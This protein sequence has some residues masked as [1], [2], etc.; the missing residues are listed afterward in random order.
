[1]GLFPLKAPAFSSLC[2]F[3][4]GASSTTNGINSPLY[5]QQRYCNGLVWP[6]VLSQRLGLTYNS[7][8]NCSYFGDTSKAVIVTNLPKWKPPADAGTALFVVWAADADYVN[9][10]G[11]NTPSGLTN[12]AMW[13]N[14]AHHFLLNHSNIIHSLYTN[15]VRTLVIPNAVDVTKVPAMVR[16]TS[17]ATKSF[18]R[19]QITEFNS[20][21]TNTINQGMALSP[22]MTIYYADMFGLFDTILAQ[23]TAYGFSTNTVDALDDPGLTNFSFT[24]PGA[25]YVFWDQDD[26][27]ARAQTIIA[28]TIQQMVLPTQLGP[29]TWLNGTTQMTL[30]NVPVGRDGSVQGTA[31]FSNWTPVASFSSTNVTQTL[32]FPDSTPARFYRLVFPISWTWP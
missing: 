6:E 29:P 24:G 8:Q 13:T 14:A 20:Q 4:D 27:T 32:T 25:Y 18:I 10:V 15:G 5:Y 23:Q 16:I 22:G 11:T 31:D 9:F 1:L 30:S 7:S 17:S 12:L 2:V 26:P 3:G 28:D 21:L 19:D